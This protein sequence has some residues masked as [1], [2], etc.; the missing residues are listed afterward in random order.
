MLSQVADVKLPVIRQIPK[1]EAWDREY[2]LMLYHDV[3][4]YVYS[5]YTVKKALTLGLYL[6]VPLFW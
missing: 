2:S 1:K 3:F 6:T 5:L 4:P